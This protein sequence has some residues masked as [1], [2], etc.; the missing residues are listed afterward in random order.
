M[1][2]VLPKEQDTLDEHSNLNRMRKLDLHGFSLDNANKHTKKFID[3]AYDKK[4]KKLLIVTGKGLRSK[5]HD[6]PYVSE[7]LN[8]LK[9]SVPEFIKNNQELSAKISKISRASQ[10]DGGDGAFY[11]FLKN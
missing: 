8:V 10:E 7:E 2:N 5:L 4:Y 3:K 6:N 9:N 1:D 11:I